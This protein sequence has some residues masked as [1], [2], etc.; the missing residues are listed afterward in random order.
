MVKCW[1]EQQIEHPHRYHI[2]QAGL[3]KLGTYMDRVIQVPVYAFA[4]SKY[5]H[6]LCRITY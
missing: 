5:D 2:I 4:M 6:S 1:S 3:D